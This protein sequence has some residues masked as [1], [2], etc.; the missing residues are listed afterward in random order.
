MQGKQVLM[1]FYWM[2]FIEGEKDRDRD[3]DRGIPSIQ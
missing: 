1:I 2:E 3:R